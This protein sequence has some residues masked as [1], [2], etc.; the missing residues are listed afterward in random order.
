MKPLRIEYKSQKKKYDKLAN[1]YY[2]FYF[3]YTKIIAQMTM[4]DTQIY[5][6]TYIIYVI[7]IHF[8]AL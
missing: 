5:A 2:P 4:P 1:G 6:H 7:I 8:V 3:I